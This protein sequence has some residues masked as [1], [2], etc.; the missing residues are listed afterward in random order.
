MET[1]PLADLRVRDALEIDSRAENLNIG[2]SVEIIDERTSRIHVDVSGE[3]E[4]FDFA[5]S[6]EVLLQTSNAICLPCTR[7]D[8][9]YVDSIKM[10]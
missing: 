3:V 6:H 8:G 7:K 10:N 5:D 9:A 2:F 4:T 1:D